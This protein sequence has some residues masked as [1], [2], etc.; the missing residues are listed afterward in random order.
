MKTTLKLFAIELTPYSFHIGIEG[1]AG[2]KKVRLIIDTG[3]SQTVISS[4]LVQGMKLKT[5]Q[6]QQHNITVGIGEGSLNPEFTVI[7]TLT[8][9]TLK[10]KDVPCI[11]LPMDHINTTYK[12]IGHKSIDGI[13][14][15]DL[16]MALES[17][18]H[19]RKLTLKVS[20]K[21][22]VFDFGEYIQTVSGDSL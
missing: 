11:V 12:S 21:G 1:K 20:T 17:R 5:H 18:L 4:Q 14:G 10:I 15:N 9:E 6:P 19:M 8:L 7:K 3:A 16:L 2:R 22:K 13:I